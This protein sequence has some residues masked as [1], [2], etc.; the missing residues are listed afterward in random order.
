MEQ[1]ILHRMDRNIGEHLSRNRRG[2]YD[3]HG[4]RLLG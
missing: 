1:R 2:W 4:G 3:W